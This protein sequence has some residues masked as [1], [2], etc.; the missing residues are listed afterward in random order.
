VAKTDVLAQLKDIHLPKPIGAWPL[1]YGWYGLMLLVFLSAIG[2]SYFI[3]KRR[4]YAR[5]KKQALELLSTY[6][7]HYEKEKNTQVTSARISELL[8]RVALV[9]FPRKEVASLHGEAWIHFL[10]Q[11][12]KKVDFKPVQG[13]LLDSPFKT[14]EKIDLQ[15]LI[16]RA[17]QWIKQRGGP[18]LN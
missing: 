7:Q 8:R 10:N 14:S 9:Y 3:F 6:K 11:T 5:P 1:A 15:P 13:M 12:S 16:L 17:E 2:V 4:K 18:C